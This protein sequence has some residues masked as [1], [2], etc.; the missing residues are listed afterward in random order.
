MNGRT[1]AVVWPED[2][3]EQ[4]WALHLRGLAKRQIAVQVDLHRDTVAKLINECYREF[5]AE[6]RARL[7]RKLESA[8]AHM[9]HIQAQAWADH[10]ADD[11]RE[12]AVLEAAVPGARY[13]SQRSQYL[14]LAL[15]AEKE[16]A[17]LEGLYADDVQETVGVLFRI[18]R[19]ERVER[20]E[21]IERVEVVKH[22]DSQ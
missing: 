15:D 20:V 18:E 19:V 14:R 5:G 6:R 13:Q 8:V 21:R 9:Q 7:K 2:K 12:C 16:I 4:V 10:D 1:P 17:R 22:D 11:A 3:R